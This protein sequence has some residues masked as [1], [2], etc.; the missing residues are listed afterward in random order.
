MALAA[1]IPNF[2]AQFRYLPEELHVKN[3]HFS[4]APSSNR[5]EPGTDKK[6]LNWTITLE[7]EYKPS[8]NRVTQLRLARPPITARTTFSTTGTTRAASIGNT[9]LPSF[10]Q[11]VQ[12]TTPS[13]APILSVNIVPLHGRSTTN[14]RALPPTVS[15][16][17]SRPIPATTA[18]LSAPVAIP[19]PRSTSTSRGRHTT[20]K[21]ICYIRLEASIHK[22]NRVQFPQA[23][24]QVSFRLM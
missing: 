1:R 17:P 11:V 20:R 7:C 23:P 18:T 24:I 5:T 2:D 19:R 14:S 15:H 12:S 6:I 22:D 4:G 8:S 10:T 9:P 21:K 3:I 13:Q 16:L